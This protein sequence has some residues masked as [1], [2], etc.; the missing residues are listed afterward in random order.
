MSESAPTHHRVTGAR[1]LSAGTSPSRQC[2]GRVLHQDTGR[3]VAEHSRLLELLLPLL[4]EHGSAGAN[5]DE[6]TGGVSLV[7][8]VIPGYAGGSGS[9]DTRAPWRVSLMKAG[10]V[11]EVLALPHRVPSLGRAVEQ[12][13][14]AKRLSVNGRSY[15][16]TLLTVVGDLSV[17]LALAEFTAERLWHVLEDRWGDASAATWNNRLTALGR[18][19]LRGPSD[20]RLTACPGY[21]RADR[22]GL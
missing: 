7:M 4:G 13:L 16:H 12:F 17:A 21:A 19:G 9:L 20:T 22:C 1:G 6:D 10:S 3:A 15:A 11:V 14:A 8:R 5:G 2:T 18:S